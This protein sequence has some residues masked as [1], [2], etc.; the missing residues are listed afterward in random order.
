MTFADKTNLGEGDEMKKLIQVLIV[1][2]IILVMGGTASGNTLPGCFG[3]AQVFFSANG[4]KRVVK[5]NQ[6][7]EPVFVKTYQMLEKNLDPSYKSWRAA[8]KFGKSI[9]TM[10]MKTLLKQPV[11]NKSKIDQTLKE[12]MPIINSATSK[13]KQLDKN[14]IERL[15]EEWQKN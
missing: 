10:A 2:G 15:K 8:W 1:S 12:C 11:V 4:N 6:N 13:I 9:G 3:M 5:Q 7:M 14:T